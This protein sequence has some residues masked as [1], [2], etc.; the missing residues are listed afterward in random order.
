MDSS[1]V[2]VESF[3]LCRSLEIYNN[4]LFL[5]GGGWSAVGF[6][7]FPGV[8][9]SFHIAVRLVVPFTETNQVLEFEVM[10]EDEDGA[11]VLPRPMR[12]AVTV[13]RPVTLIRGEEQ[14]V[15]VPLTFTGI[16]IPHEGT[17][18][19][20]FLFQGNELARTS[21]TALAIHPGGFAE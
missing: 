19:F 7:S 10:M 12:P 6:P 15:H 20:R 9:G 3:L 2:R 18:L 1:K 8:L 5:L 14:A 16:E 13:G 21:F 17:Y 4:E 11:S